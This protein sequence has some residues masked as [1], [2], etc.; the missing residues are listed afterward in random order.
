[1]SGTVTTHTLGAQVA[2]E[3]KKIN[4]V[5]AGTPPH[6]T[7]ILALLGQTETS[8]TE[9]LPEVVSLR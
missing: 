8:D 6:P 3:E 7:P 2:K 5:A 4:L 9:I 1:M